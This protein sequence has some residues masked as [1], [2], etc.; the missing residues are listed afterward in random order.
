MCS[1]A[2]W[3]VNER[4]R[5][6]ALTAKADLDEPNEYGGDATLENQWGSGRF[7]V[8]GQWPFTLPVEGFAE[9]EV[10]D[11]PKQICGGCGR[12][13]QRGRCGVQGSLGKSEKL[14][15]A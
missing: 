9:G 6:R 15:A 10:Y 3:R 4:T 2:T 14:P 1:E 7:C 5:E 8:Q 11:G 13:A 12:F